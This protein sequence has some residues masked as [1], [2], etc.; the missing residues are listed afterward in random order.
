VSAQTAAHTWSAFQSVIQLSIALNAAYATLYSFVDDL[1]KQ[2][3]DTALKLLSRLSNVPQ[4]T[5]TS[6]DQKEEA[7]SILSKIYE[8]EE[9]LHDANRYFMKPISAIFSLIGIILLVVSAYAGSQDPISDFW[10]AVCVVRGSSRCP[11]L[12]NM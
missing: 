1:L 8:W 2:E 7:R 5:P 6:L 11:R 12:V 9:E 3:T 10:V 4:P